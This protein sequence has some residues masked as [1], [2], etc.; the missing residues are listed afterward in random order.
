ISIGTV[1][2]ETNIDHFY[3][4]LKNYK[5]KKG[6]IITTESKIP[7]S[8]GNVVPVT[9]W[10]KI[11]SIESSNVFFPTEAAQELTNEGIDIRDTILP[12]TRDELICKVI[13][14]GFTLKD[15]LKLMPLNY[16]VCP[17]SS[18]SYPSSEDV[19][20]L[21][22]SDLDSEHPLFIGSLLARDAVKIRIDADNLVSRHVSIFGMSGSGKT[23]MVRR[24]MDELLRKK[25]PMLVLDIHGDYLGFIQK[26]KKLYPKN[27]VKLFYPNLSVSSEDKEIIYTLIDKLGN[28]LTDPQKD[29]LSSLLEKVKYEGGSLLKY[30]ELLVRKAREF[31]K[32]PAKFSK[33][34]RPAS[35]YVV[36]R[37]LGQ[38]VKKLKNMEQTNFRHR[39]KMSKLKFEELP[40][41][42]TEPEKIINKGQLSIL[43]LKG[44]ENLPASAIVSILLEN[45][46]KHRQEV[47]EE[48]PPFLTIIE[49]A[50]N[51]IP[52]RSEDKD[53]LPSVET[54]R[55]VITE[56]RKFGTGVMI[57]S[58]RPSRL[59]ETI[60][61]QCN[62]QIVF[63]MVN[64]KDQR[65]TTRDSETLSVDDSKQLPNLA[66]GQGII[67]GQVVNFS[68][69]VQIK[70]DADLINDDIG[71]ENF[72]T[73][74]ENWDD[75]ESV[76]QRKKFAKD[77]SNITSIDRRRAN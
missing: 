56:G 29:F 37:S 39:Q 48:I 36:V 44:Y 2:G 76:K 47:E 25:Y 13:I 22:I 71:N 46:F 9:V 61:S 20:A 50:H 63:R 41:A 11:S 24:I 23:V 27:E 12:S 26:Q 43:Y 70:F 72:I 8:E 17:A 77:F 45:L 33:S 32:D 58:Q 66:N 28:S 60:A 31:A 67:S 30:I 49:E 68:L 5:A 7:S 34:V 65:A 1:L 64:Q 69:P 16:P 10:G 55:K 62:S 51:F 4:S 40:D 54:I 75:K 73:A 35:M 59:D 42:A 14:L 19:E 74:V 6:D 52:S 53:N 3:F 21:L 15:N 57:I 18:V 38:V